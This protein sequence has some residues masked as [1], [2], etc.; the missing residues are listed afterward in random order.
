[1]QSKAEL[2]SL[3]AQTKSKMSLK[4]SGGGATLLQKRKAQS[5]QISASSTSSND[6]RTPRKSDLFSGYESSDQSDHSG[7]D[8][9]EESPDC[10]PNGKDNG[11]DDDGSDDDGLAD[12]GDWKSKLEIIHRV[13]HRNEVEL[14]LGLLDSRH[15]KSQS[16]L[17][18]NFF[19]SSPF[20]QWTVFNILKALWIMAGFILCLTAN[21]I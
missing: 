10:T 9:E 11:S 13:P 12:N 15:A 19:L 7:Q 16:V 2:L 3:I 1:M 6:V 8:D 20:W 4:D 5:S 21:F 14:M 18:Q 17:Y